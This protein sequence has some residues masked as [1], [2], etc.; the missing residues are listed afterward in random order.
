MEVGVRALSAH[1]SAEFNISPGR[2]QHVWLVAIVSPARWGKMDRNNCHTALVNFK[3]LISSLHH[4]KNNA[5]FISLIGCFFLI[6]IVVI[7]SF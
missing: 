4:Y 7:F 1:S 6:C 2:W 5:C 3:T